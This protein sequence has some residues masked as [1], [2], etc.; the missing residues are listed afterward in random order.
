MVSAFADDITVFESHSM[1]IKAVKK[2][3]VRYEQV[4]GAKI[5]FDES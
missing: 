2:A 4:I 3:V 1:D 5:N